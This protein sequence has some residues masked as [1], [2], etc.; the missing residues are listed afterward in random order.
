MDEP[1][2]I[3][4]TCQTWNKSNYVKSN[5]EHAKLVI[6]DQPNLKFPN[7]SYFKN[8]ELQLNPSNELNPAKHLV[9]TLA[10]SDHFELPEPLVSCLKEPFKNYKPPG[11]KTQLY[12]N[13]YH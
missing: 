6:K 13:Y 3:C 7:F 11:Y 1:K 2:K 4:W 12:W 9:L 8:F 10:K 5:I